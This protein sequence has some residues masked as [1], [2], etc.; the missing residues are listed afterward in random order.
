MAEGQLM[1][2]EAAQSLADTSHQ[3]QALEAQ[4]LG[5]FR[6]SMQRKPVVERSH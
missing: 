2:Y 5:I 1:G 6:P 4:K 3:Q